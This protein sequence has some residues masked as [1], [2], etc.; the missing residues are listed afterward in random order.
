MKLV[1]RQKL[2]ATAIILGITA[3]PFT[4]SPWLSTSTAFAAQAD[5]ASMA[6]VRTL[7]LMTGGAKGDFMPDKV[8][9][10]A[11]MAKILCNIFE[12]NVKSESKTSYLDVSSANWSA[13][14]IEA[15]QAAGY[16]QGNGEL[17]YPN[18]AVT[19]QELITSLV[20][21]MDLHSE[22]ADGS[23]PSAID[24][25][26]SY[27]LAIADNNADAN[28]PLSR[29]TSADLFIQLLDH[30]VGQVDAQGSTVRV[31]NIPYKVDGDLQGLFGIENGSVL[32]GA[33]LNIDRSQRTVTNI[34]TIEL[35]S[36]GGVFDG[37]GISF[38]GNLIVNGSV[39]L[40]NIQ[41]TGN[42]Q[43][44]GEQGAKLTAKLDNSSWGNVMISSMDS[45][46]QASG[47]S[48]VGKLTLS[49]TATV[50]TE[51]T[52]SIQ[53]L[54][55]QPDLKKLTLNGA[56]DVLDASLY[57][58]NPLVTL[59]PA[60]VVGNITLSKDKSANDVILNYGAQKS[61]VSMIN[62][63]KNT[64]NPAPAA[65][66]TS[67]TKKKDKDKEKDQ[68]IIGLD[69]SGLMAG[70][71]KANDLLLHPQEMPRLD[72]EPGPWDGML[73]QA[74][75]N[76]T[77][78]LNKTDSTQQDVDTAVLELNASM[79]RYISSQTSLS[80]FF[81][82]VMTV[83]HIPFN[84]TDVGRFTFKDRMNNFEKDYYNPLTT[85]AQFDE[86]IAIVDE[87]R[88]QFELIQNVDFTELNQK[89]QY[90]QDLSHSPFNPEGASKLLSLYDRYT[91]KMHQAMTQDQV[92]SLLQQLTEEL[93]SSGGG[94][95]HQEE[96][97]ES[98]RDKLELLTGKVD[99]VLY[100][101][102][103]HLQ[104]Y[105]PKEF[106]IINEALQQGNSVL[107]GQNT[108]ISDEEAFNQLNQAWSTFRVAYD[109]KLN[110]LRSRLNEQI[111][112][113]DNITKQNDNGLS[114][115]SIQQLLSLQSRAQQALNDR[116]SS[117]SLLGSF[118]N[119]IDQELKNAQPK[120]TTRLLDLIEQSKMEY[121]HYEKYHG[122]DYKPDSYKDN[123]YFYYM[124]TD[125]EYLV[126]DKKATQDQLDHYE[127]RL[128]LALD[129][130]STDW[131]L[132]HMIQD[133][134]QKAYMDMDNARNTSDEYY[135]NLQNAANDLQDATNNLKS[136]DVP[137]VEL[138]KLYIN[139]FEA[140]RTFVA[141][142]AEISEIPENSAPENS[143]E[144]PVADP[145]PSAPTSGTEETTPA[146]G[147][148]TTPAT[149]TPATQKPATETTPD[150]GSG[151]TSQPVENN[152][153][154]TSF[155]P[156]DQHYDYSAPPQNNQTEAA[157][158]TPVI[159]AEPETTEAP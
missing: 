20:K 23:S 26:R 102:N 154:P 24:I 149:E 64:E 17:F 104:F 82:F 81:D 12:L 15:V 56:V 101:A 158:P 92:N 122:N 157:A 119:M 55:I 109:L 50:Q 83:R 45:I 142:Q 139:L 21:A 138:R 61:A 141:H 67:S 117:V 73:K 134:L 120:N 76:A 41:S 87:M 60:A 99:T 148:E 28:A 58:G 152:Q 48:K 1:N 18:Q 126:N 127:I 140:D 153:P 144:T 13:P 69:V 4:S 30:P 53:Q 96:P 47:S 84:Y 80:N 121:K 86:Y 123:K 107:R 88:T 79:E 66:T 42:L 38:S 36:N 136:N 63:T 118:Q 145:S 29:Q 22:T 100:D 2:I 8:L 114:E 156:A 108:S 159:A 103:D 32:K 115:E 44:N 33:K 97:E 130:Y 116:Y 31:G 40:K 9:T 137:F 150:S 143:S 124:F 90:I 46:L 70:I 128:K 52:A 65:N 27:G 16:M 43:I 34:N 71:E 85:K 89:L 14:Y 51:D 111:I 112:S 25:A 146:S 132:P 6:E 54:T 131:I 11:E 5:T 7:G 133:A 57:N 110:D 75:G 19:R 35:N 129:D 147:T 94:I 49:N 105:M 106:P 59:Q 74:I 3:T 113:I 10:R 125:A 91:N 93:S 155:E 95:S 77:D 78:A 68:E 37:K 98:Y 151:Q 39:T 62:G 135:V 72:E